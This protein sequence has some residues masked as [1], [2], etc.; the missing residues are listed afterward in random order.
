MEVY[1]NLLL[2]MNSSLTVQ[3]ARELEKQ[4]TH[5][6][7]NTAPL[8]RAVLPIDGSAGSHWISSQ[9][10]C[11][12]SNLRLITVSELKPLFCSNLF[13]H[14]PILPLS[15]YQTNQYM[16]PTNPIWCTAAPTC[17]L[18]KSARD[19]YPSIDPKPP[20]LLSKGEQR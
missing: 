11:K 17:F 20:K 15:A 18:D 10:G 14:Q 9:L 6:T 4:R 1:M 8:R 7:A 19:L 12:S 2:C 3:K 16:D 13:P 5:Y